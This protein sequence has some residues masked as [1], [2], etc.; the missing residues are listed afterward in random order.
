MIENI[1]ITII[2]VFLTG[3]GMYL[4]VEN[5]KT[6]PTPYEHWLA[7]DKQKYPHLYEDEDD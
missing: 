4:H 6:A 1:I 3:L 5:H 7:E 2:A